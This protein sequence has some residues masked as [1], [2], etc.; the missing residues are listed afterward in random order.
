MHARVNRVGR[1]ES[2]DGAHGSLYTPVNT[3]NKMP[4]TSFKRQDHTIAVPTILG[5]FYVCTR[6]KFFQTHSSS[7]LLPGLNDVAMITVVGNPSTSRRKQK[8]RFEEVKKNH[9]DLASPT[10]DPGGAQIDNMQRTFSGSTLGRSL[11]VY[12]LNFILFLGKAPPV[13]RLSAWRATSLSKGSFRVCTAVCLCKA[14]SHRPLGP[15]R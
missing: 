4:T 13:R 1:P 7:G 6:T 9:V 2:V 15:P 12:P 14:G 3:P 5:P 8:L 11:Y 10:D